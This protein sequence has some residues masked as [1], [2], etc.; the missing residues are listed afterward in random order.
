MIRRYVSNVGP[1]AYVTVKYSKPVG[2]SE[3][4]NARKNERR[5]EIEKRD[6]E[7]EQEREKV[8]KNEQTNDGA[9]ETTRKN[10]V[11]CSL[12]CFPL[13]QRAVILLR[14]VPDSSSARWLAHPLYPSLPF[15]FRTFA[16]TF[17][18]SFPSFRRQSDSTKALR[19]AVFSRVSLLFP[20]SPPSEVLDC[21]LRSISCASIRPI[22]CYHY[23]ADSQEATGTHVLFF[24]Y[25]SW[26]K[27]FPLVVSA[28]FDR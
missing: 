26:P 21:V 6:R 10:P 7:N 27:Y 5:E 18:G 14:L 19:L 16:T 22:T 9:R 2:F 11:A 28:P 20:T 8:G 4:S 13:A 1:V 24:N 23:S 3:E 15:S 17:L 12:H 25:L